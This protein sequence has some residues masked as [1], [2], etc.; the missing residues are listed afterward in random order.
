LYSFI[1]SKLVK[2][3]GFRVDGTIQPNCTSQTL[4]QYAKLNA[5]S[6][7]AA[8]SSNPSQSKAYINHVQEMHHYSGMLAAS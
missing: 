8:P 1:S 2:T 3:H 5:K 4:K 7:L 6:D